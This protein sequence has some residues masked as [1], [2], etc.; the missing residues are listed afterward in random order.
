[1][2]ARGSHTVCLIVCLLAIAVMPLHAQQDM[3]AR[4]E[5]Y[6]REYAGQEDAARHLRLAN[7]FFAYLL[8]ADYIDE[9]ISFPDGAHI[10]SVDVNVYYYMAEWY[11]GEGDYQSAIDYCTMAC[12][13]VGG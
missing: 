10:D 7:E 8:E 5:Q 4:M 6:A 1:M 2:K 3:G 12:T 9:A 13:K 11:Y